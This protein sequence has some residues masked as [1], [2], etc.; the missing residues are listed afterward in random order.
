MSDRLPRPWLFPLLV[1]AATWVLIL[2]SWQAANLHGHHSHG[3]YF[4][5]WYK[6]SGYYAGIAKLWYAPDPGRAGPPIS[7]AFFPLYPAL[8]WLASTITGGNMHVAGLI[9]TLISGVAAVFAFWALA[10]RA[11]DRWVADRATLLLCA[12]PGAMTLGMMYSE[13]LGIALAAGSLLAALNRKWLIAGLLAALGSAEHPTLIVLTAAL[14]IAAAEAIRARREWRALIA[15]ALAPLG[16]IGYFAWIGTRY[17]D[18][19]FWSKLERKYWAHRIDWGRRTYHLLTWSQPHMRMS[20]HLDY[21]VLVIAMIVIGAIAV[22][23]MLAARLPLPVTAYSAAIYAS[24]IFTQEAGPTPRYLWAAF[25]IFIGAAAKLP[26]WIYWPVLVASAASLF[27]L[28]GWWP[29]HPL[30]PPPLSSGV[31][32]WPRSCITSSDLACFSGRHERA[33]LRVPVTFLAVLIALGL[34]GALSARLGGSDVRRAVLRVVI[35][36][37]LGLAFTYGVGHL[38][39]TAIG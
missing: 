32:R 3:W 20:K 10:A 25:G 26:R 33:G 9:A 7:A 29:N 23:L 31:T 30:V 15:P 2:A 18:Y 39:G 5:L 13:P 37:A 24:L 34:T 22:A 19:L 16:M 27:F 11:R 17:H 4:Y 21:N 6:D 38:F 8:I 14:G 28:V 1:F 36:G 12:F 35:G